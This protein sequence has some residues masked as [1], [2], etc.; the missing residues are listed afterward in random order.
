MVSTAGKGG[1]FLVVPLFFREA[2]ISNIK[3]RNRL[4]KNPLVFRKSCFLGA[5]RWNSYKTRVLSLLPD[6]LA[7][8]ACGASPKRAL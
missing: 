3:L 4:M 7:V 5:L 1:F 6:V 2:T 8:F